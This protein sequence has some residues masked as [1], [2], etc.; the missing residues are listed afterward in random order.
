MISSST[1][2]LSPCE[3]A[4]WSYRP[5]AEAHDNTPHPRQSSAP[6]TCLQHPLGNGTLSPPPSATQAR[7]MQW[8]GTRGH[9]SGQR[10]PGSA[11]L[12]H[13]RAWFVDIIVRCLLDAEQGRLVV[14]PGRSTR[15]HDRVRLA[16]PSSGSGSRSRTPVSFPQLY[17]PSD[18]MPSQFAPLPPCFTSHVGG[19]QASPDVGPSQR[20]DWGGS[21]PGRCRSSGIRVESRHGRDHAW[22]G[23]RSYGQQWDPRWVLQPHLLGS[24]I[25][26]TKS[27]GACLAHLPRV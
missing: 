17:G 15:L 2:S 1:L 25:L 3:F 6:Q 12:C 14:R 16:G 24:G 7:E 10:L 8:E 9:R 18:I 23:A 22:P 27:R 26:G 20:L 5:C 21:V 19:M 11:V 4:R 13:H